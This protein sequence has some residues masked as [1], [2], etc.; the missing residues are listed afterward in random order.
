M[1]RREVDVPGCGVDVGMAEQ[2]LHHSQVHA[3][4]GQRRPERVPKR[5]RGAGTDLRRGGFRLPLDEAR[6]HRSRR[7]PWDD[8]MR[9]APK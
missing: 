3:G 2:R 5:V 8:P 6:R 9:P 7:S 1:G 4:L